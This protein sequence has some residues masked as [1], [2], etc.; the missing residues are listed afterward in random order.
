[1]GVLVVAAAAVGAVIGIAGDARAGDGIRPR[2]PVTWPEDVPCLLEVDRAVAATVEL[3]Y[4]IPFEDPMAGASITRDEVPDGRRQQFF[5]FA[6]DIDPRVAMPEWISWDDV[7]AAAA[8]GLTDP[9]TVEDAWVLE[10]HPLLAE[11]FVRIDPDDARRPITFATAAAGASWDT[12][13]LAPGTYVVRAYTWDPWPNLWAHPRRGAVRVFDDVDD[14]ALVPALAVGID[15]AVLHRNE[16]GMLHGCVAAPVGTTLSAAWADFTDP[17]GAFTEFGAIEVSGDEI[18]IPFEPPEALWGKF[19][20]V[21]VTAI[22][23]AG[24]RYDAFVPESIT[25]LA[26]D[27]PSDCEGGSFV[28][29]CSTSSGDGGTTDPG[30]LGAGTGAS[31]AGTTESSGSVTGSTEGGGS[32]A[33]PVDAAGGCG[34]RH[35]QPGA[36][37]LVLGIAMAWLGRRRTRRHHKQTRP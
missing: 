21:R 2:T 5:A 31:E 14:P 13:M 27:A 3:P 34:C 16:L 6:A 19:A 35:S 24:L 22:D 30:T 32:A 37:A 8:L 28:E 7:T 15:T 29:G 12:S 23:P 25:I 18:A 17:D 36:R 4:A 33:S 1:M 26:S 11:L 10:S 9:A 20:V